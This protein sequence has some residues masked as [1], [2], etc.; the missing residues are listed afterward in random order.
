LY[1][2]KDLG[3][4]LIDF[5]E[6]Y[7][8]QFNYYSCGISI[9]DGGQY[10]SKKDRGWENP[11]KPYLLAAEDPHDIENDV[12][13]NSFSML[14]VRTSFSFA[15]YLLR[16]EYAAA[17]TPLSRILYIDPKMEQYRQHIRNLYYNLADELVKRSKSKEGAARLKSRFVDIPY[18]F[19]AV[20]HNLLSEDNWK[21][22]Q[23]E[24]ANKM[25]MQTHKKFQ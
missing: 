21:H 5:F 24:R 11:V 18:L 13:R 22:S 8:T 7:G 15:F 16:A 1:D 25:E 14:N 6:F 12:G 23:Q 19:K 4:L 3:F 20:L 2:E 10:F 9:R 17:A